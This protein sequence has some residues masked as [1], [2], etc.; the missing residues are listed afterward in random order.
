M[1]NSLSRLGHMEAGPDNLKFDAL[2]TLGQESSEGMPIRH[3]VF[4]CGNLTWMVRGYAHRKFM[5]IGGGIF[6]NGSVKPG[7]RLK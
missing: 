5:R 2:I 3:T 1:L 6:M 4:A 7:L